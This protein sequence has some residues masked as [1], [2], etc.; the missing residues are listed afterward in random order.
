MKIYDGFKVFFVSLT[1]FAI[2]AAT[3]AQTCVPATAAAGALDTCFGTG[4]KVMTDLTPGNDVA[5]AVVAQPDGKIIVA[6]EAD[7]VLTPQTNYL[8]ADFA[9]VRYNADG[10]LDTTFDG[11]GIVITDVGAGENDFDSVSSVALQSDGKIVVAGSARQS[12]NTPA[13]AIVRYNTDGSLDTTFDGDGIKLFVL[14]ATLMHIRDM[15]IQP[16]GKIVVVGP[17]YLNNQRYSLIARFNPDGSLDTYLS[18]FLIDTTAVN[19]QGN[20]ILTGG[21]GNGGYLTVRRLNLNLVTPDTSFGNNGEASFPTDAFYAVSLEVRLDGSIISNWQEWSFGPPRPLFFRFNSDGSIVTNTSYFED[22]SFRDTA[23]QSDGKLLSAGKSNNPAS[24]FSIRRFIDSYQPDPTFSG[25]RVQV[26]FLPDATPEIAE[27]IDITTRRDNK[28]VVVGSIAEQTT[29]ATQSKFAVAQLQSGLRAPHPERFD[30]DGDGKADLSIFRPSN[31]EWWISKSSNGG[32]A[33]FQFG[34]GTDTLTPGDYTGDGKTDIA[35]F[36]Q[37]TGEWF[38]LRS[39][40]NSYYSFPFGTSGDIPRPS[41]FDGDGKTDY[42]VYRP[43]QNF[44]YRINSIGITLNGQFGI[45]GDKPVTGDF[46]GDGKSDKA[47]FRPSTG[48]W[49]WQSSADNVAR[50]THLGVSSD[51]PVAADYDGDGKTDFAVYRP[52]NGTWYIINSGNGSLTIMNFG[53]AEDKPAPAD[54]D[55]DG[56]ADIVVFRPSSG[57]WYQMRSTAGFAAQQFGVSGDVPTEN[58]FVQ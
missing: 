5:R 18:L 41:D 53:L 12:E 29:P 35:F 8:K 45:D 23:L 33:A 39:E 10:S 32:N 50:A 26:K 20:K 46:D 47:I 37:S 2:V 34:A 24:G 9:V 11:D 42:I 55:G 1:I 49:W 56:K 4:G 52:S 40:D 3:Q 16:D 57:V 17:A 28:I 31:G 15:V 58:A 14:S 30:Y 22:N 19:M 25:G 44:W 27:A 6:G 43:S 36:R 48:D 21:T 54:Y 38:V 51:V 7:I 13:F